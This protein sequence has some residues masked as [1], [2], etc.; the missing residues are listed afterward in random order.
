MC[1]SP[2]IAIAVWR[3]VIKFSRR[4]GLQRRILPSCHFYELFQPLRPR[5]YPALA[6]SPAL[7]LQ[8]HPTL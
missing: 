4:S 1:L 6:N 7:S 3:Q 5:E 8:A 2:R